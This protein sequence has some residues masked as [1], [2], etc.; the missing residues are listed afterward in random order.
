MGAVPAFAPPVPRPNRTVLIV[1][2]VLGATLLLCCGGGVTGIGGLV[3]YGYDTLQKDAVGTVEAYLGDLQAG[4]YPQ[5]Y[6]RLC[7][8]EKVERTLTE[9]TGEEETARVTE[10]QVGSDIEVDAENNWLVTARVARQGNSSRQETF[11]VLFDD[12]NAAVICPR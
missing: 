4:R 10:Y 1:S 3:W 12:T 9:F 7:A 5:A 2:L 11:P 6:S 8:E